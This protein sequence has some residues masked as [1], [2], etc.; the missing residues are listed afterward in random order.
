MT[1]L[2]PRGVEPRLAVPDQ[3]RLMRTRSVMGTLA[4]LTP[5]YAPDFGLCSD[6]HRT[7][8]EHTD[9]EVVHHIV[10]PDGDAERFAV[11]RSGRCRI[12]KVSELLPRRIRKLPAV[13]AWLN[14][15]HPLLPI[16]GWVMQQIVKL[17][18]TPL[19]DSEVVVL[20]D[21]DVSLVRHMTAETWLRNG[22]LKLYRMPD[23]VDDRLPQ[24]SA[25]HDVSRELLGLSSRTPPLPDF[26]SPLNV[27]DANVVRALQNRIEN[28]AGE[29]WIDAIGRRVNFSEFIL[30]GVFAEEVL[31]LDPFLMTSSSSCLC[32]WDTEPLD[33]SS[34]REFGMQLSIDEVAVMIS[35]KSRTSIE[36]RRRALMD[37]ART[38]R[39]GHA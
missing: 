7:V 1:P 13:N 34:A 17:A 19:L 24:H 12:W 26:I 6:L 4:V 39:N 14:T 33:T 22:E 25:W 18:V 10:T 32:Y 5:S 8:L 28:T 36:V 30:Y 16:R 31:G 3:D 20:A 37:V 38:I 23:A 21:S 29:S 2:A 11:L 35:A 15:R 9:P 27:W